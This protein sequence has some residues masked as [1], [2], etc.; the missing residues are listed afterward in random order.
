[1]F[2]ALGECFVCTTSGRRLRGRLLTRK[3]LLQGG[4]LRR[5]LLVPGRGR[6][7]RC[8]ACTRLLEKLILDIIKK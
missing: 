6:G 5:S 3:A 8:F 4:A 7:H 1:M 2:S